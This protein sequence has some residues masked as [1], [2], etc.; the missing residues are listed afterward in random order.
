LIDPLEK[1]LAMQFG[2]RTLF[3]AST[4]VAV[5]CAIFFALPLIVEIPI[6]ALIVLVTPSIWI[7]GACFARGPWRA[8]FLGGI[9]AAWLPHACLMFYGAM[10]S[11]ALLDGDSIA[12]LM[13]MSGE[14][15]LTTRLV[16]A[17]CFLFPGFVACIGGGCS[18]L[19]YRWFGPESA[20]KPAAQTSRLHEPYVLL[21]SR[22]TPL[23]DSLATA[24][25]RREFA[26]E[27]QSAESPPWG[28]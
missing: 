6:L 22:V 20:T 1:E 15:D 8:F 13:Q 25:T 18:A 11:G 12:E 10:T 27:R 9:I 23:Q 26:M 5:F 17:A 2:L 14:Y 3:A 24:T 16:V 21:E 28:G 19:V 4:L 7:C